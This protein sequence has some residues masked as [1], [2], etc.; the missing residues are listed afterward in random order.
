MKNNDIRVSLCSV[1]VEGV[2]SRLDRKRSE[3][4]LSIT[5]KVALLV[6]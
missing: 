2:G 5:P 4:S 6:L 1:P 3:G